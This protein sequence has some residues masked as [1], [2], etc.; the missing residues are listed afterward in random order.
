M[1]DQ[2]F[3]YGTTLFFL[4]VAMQAVGRFGVI[5]SQ[6]HLDSTSFAL[7]GEYPAVT[8][9]E[10]VSEADGPQAIELY[11]GY[12]RDHQPE[13]KPFLLNPICSA[14]GGI[15]VWWWAAAMRAIA[16]PLRGECERLP[17]RGRRPR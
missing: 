4:K 17:S 5:I 6:C 9:A 8:G 7:D 10:S 13:L 12:S 11:R 2:W 14:D 16:K 15:L 3:E 1:L